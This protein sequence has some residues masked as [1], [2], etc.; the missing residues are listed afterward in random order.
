MKQLIIIALVQ[1][2]FFLFF[3]S[4]STLHTRYSAVTEKSII[5]GFVPLGSEPRLIYNAIIIKTLL[6]F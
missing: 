6:R 5:I 3:V 1:R 4:L 2:N